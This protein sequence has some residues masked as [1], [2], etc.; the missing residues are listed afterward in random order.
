MPQRSAEFEDQMA[1]PKTDLLIVG[2]HYSE[3]GSFTFN[4]IFYTYLENLGRILFGEPI[5]HKSDIFYLELIHGSGTTCTPPDKKSGVNLTVKVQISHPTHIKFK[6][7]ILW[8]AI[9]LK[10]PT[11]RTRK[12]VKCPGY[13]PGGMLKFELIRALRHAHLRKQACWPMKGLQGL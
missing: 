8:K 11:P 4:P 2:I 3:T 6:S 13:V 9:R 10:F 5:V 7:P 12:M 1:S